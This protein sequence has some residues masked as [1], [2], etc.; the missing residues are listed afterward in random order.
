MFESLNGLFACPSCR[1]ALSLKRC[2]ADAADFGW[3]ACA[4][5][6]TAVPVLRGFPHFGEFLPLVGP[7]GAAALAKLDRELAGEPD[8]YRNFVAAAARRPSF[9]LYAAFAPFNEA[10]RALYPLIEAL[11]LHLSPGDLVVDVWCRTGWTGALLAGLFPEQRV[12]S[13]WEGPSN[14]LGYAGYRYW[15]GAAARPAN[16]TIA[17]A[18]PRKGLP[19]ADGAAGLVHAA[20]SLHRFA[21]EAFLGECLRVGRSEAALV[22]PHVHLANSEPD[23]FFDRGG[24]IRHG[25]IY[26]QWLDGALD[27]DKRRGLIL[28]ERALFA[29]AGRRALADETDTADYNALIAVLKDPIARADIG[30]AVH[31]WSDSDCLIPNPLI[32]VDPASGQATYDP[33]ALAGRADYLLGRHPVYAE[34]LAERLPARLEG[35]DL[36]LLFWARTASTMSLVEMRRRLD[37][38]KASFNACIARLAW[39]EVA[40][41]ALVGGA[42]ARLQ[43]F[44]ATRRAHPPIGDHQFTTLWQGARARYGERPL[45]VSEDGSAFGWQE[46]E[47]ILAPLAALLSANGVGPDRPLVILSTVCV[48]AILS[49]WAA[50]SLGAAVAPLDPIMTSA[51]LAEL[52]GRLNPGLVLADRSMVG[53]VPTGP[54]LLCTEGPED[55]PQDDTVAGVNLLADELARYPAA[56]FPSLPAVEEGATAAILFTSGSTGRPKGVILSQGSLWRG[57]GALVEGL[58]WEQGD[59]LLSLGGLHT[60]SGLR[61][62]CVAALVAGATIV[63]PDPR[64][65]SHPATLAEACRHWQVTLLAAVPAL[66]GTVA[67]ASRAQPL[68]FAPLRQIAVT[69]SALSLALQSEGERAFGAPIQ[70][71]Y[72]L[73]ETGGVCLVSPPGTAR[74]ADGDVGLPAGAL[75]RIVDEGSHLVAPGEAGELQIYSGNLTLGYLG[76]AARTA[77]LFDHGWLR[78]GDVARWGGQ[79]HVVLLGRRDD[80]IKNRFGEIVHPAVIE[81]ALCQRPDVAEAAVIGIGEGADLK[82]TAFVVPRTAGGT[83]WLAD[84]RAG[85]I[86]MLGPRQTPDRFVEKSVL[87]RLSS[88][89]LARL[90][91]R[92]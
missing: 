38:D 21:F 20:D 22:F 70:V 8:A 36:R 40:I 28:S 39:H 35:D 9:D 65:A 46:A 71:Y 83:D 24:E 50:W 43:T 79:G 6:A 42:M 62:P 61:N 87:P 31:P 92:E 17:F 45:L 25:R 49:I 86:Q 26:R 81:A 19:F 67:A 53:L 10:T 69:G 27:G 30:P 54:V 18:D 4:P 2:G 63:L 88:G 73:T 78:T 47:E 37:L 91:L 32:S 66:V 13:L 48:E 75:A 60:M 12:V 34:R 74:L 16:W 84:L 44:H 80:Q 76:E 64:R 72:G 51:Q 89:K 59:V 57:A 56:P 68:R 41:T 85:I 7:P 23:P 5:C 52:I 14:V 1:R 58:G 15:L 3:L 77:A 11:R 55:R 90:S 29:H 82:L 33:R